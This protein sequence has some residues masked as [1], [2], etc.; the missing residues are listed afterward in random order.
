MNDSVP[1]MLKK[2][3][4]IFENRKEFSIFFESRRFAPSSHSGAA[5]DFW[6]SESLLVLSSY[7]FII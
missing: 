2:N 3:Q 5:L 7:P 4:V 1:T 6:R